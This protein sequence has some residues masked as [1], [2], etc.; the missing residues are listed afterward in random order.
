MGLGWCCLGGGADQRE[1]CCLECLLSRSGGAVRGRCC[2]GQ[3]A[4]H[5]G[6]CPGEGWFCSGGAVQRR[7]PVLSR[8]VVLS[9]ALSLTGNDI[10]TPPSPCPQTNTS[11][12]SPSRNFID[13]QQPSPNVAAELATHPPVS[14]IVEVSM[15]KIAQGTAST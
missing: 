12:T 5:G 9:G 8:G 14:S 3:C 2:P 11:E 4:V 1:W 15:K 6:C 13:G 10:I 7:G